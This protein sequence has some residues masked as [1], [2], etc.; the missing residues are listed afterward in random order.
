MRDEFAAENPN[1]CSGLNAFGFTYGACNGKGDVPDDADTDSLIAEAKAEV[2]RNAKFTGVQDAADL[3]VVSQVHAL[4]FF[5]VT[6]AP[7][8]YEGLPVPRTEI[9]VRM[10]SGGVTS[11]HGNHYV[12][13]CVPE[14]PFFSERQARESLIDLQIPWYDIGGSQRV[15]H[16]TEDDLQSEAQKVIFPSVGLGMIELSVA[17]EV[18]VGF[19]AGP[20][21]WFVYVDTMTKQIVWI[22]QLFD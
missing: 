1:I 16:V 14:R 11:I 22:E 6:F 2:V 12:D 10:D 19:G 7:Q 9:Y 15:Y 4:G 8:T 17:W 13:I 3:D 20:P 18:P 5:H 21:G